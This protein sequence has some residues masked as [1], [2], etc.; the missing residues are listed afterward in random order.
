MDLA[1]RSGFD[2]RQ[3]EHGELGEQRVDAVPAPVLEP[4]D[5]QVRALQFGQH[6]RRIGAVEHRVAQLC[7]EAAQN[8]RSQKK[9]PRVEVERLEHLVGEV[10]GDEALVPPELENRASGVADAAKPGRDEHQR[11]RPSLGVRA[12]R[13]DLLRIEGEALVFDEEASCLGSRE[14]ELVRAKLDQTTLAAE[15]RELQR[16]I[17]PRDQ[18]E[19]RRFRQLLDEIVEELVALGI[20]HGVQVVEHDDE[21]LPEGRDRVRQLV[22]RRFERIS[23]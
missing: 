19:A 6:C 11:G 4:C 2:C 5:E 16:R 21:L 18:D 13:L 3:L 15:M 9:P 1:V 22:D 10:I 17:K 8:G 14:R 20:G 23:G 7:R 12:E